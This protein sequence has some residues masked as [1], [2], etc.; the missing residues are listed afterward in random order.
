GESAEPLAYVGAAMA[1]GFGALGVVLAWDRMA[2]MTQVLVLAAAALVLAAASLI[3]PVRLP[4]FGRVADVSASTGAVLVGWAA[5]LAAHT[6]GAEVPRALAV[7]ALV[8]AAAAGAAHLRR[9]GTLPHVVAGTGVVG[10]AVWF[11]VDLG[12]EAA[13]AGTIAVAVGLA[14]WGLGLVEVVVPVR[15]AVV[16]AG[17][18]VFGG[19]AITLAAEEAWPLLPVVVA[20]I[21]FAGAALRDLEPVAHRALATATG[22]LAVAKAGLLIDDP[23]LR[24]VVV[25]LAIGVALVV[26]ATAIARRSRPIADAEEPSPQPG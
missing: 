9:N 10:A 5:G 6:L 25:G 20:T 18:N 13:L 1:L 14:W 23:A 11:G 17:L 21:L 19:A 15:A 12:A 2:A 16:G 3:T 8:G 4:A 7:G 26:A 24:L 22:L